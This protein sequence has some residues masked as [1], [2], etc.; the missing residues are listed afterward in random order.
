MPHR[1]S[2]AA[3]SC[4]PGN[5][6]R[7]PRAGSLA[8]AARSRSS[9]AWRAPTRCPAAYARRS[10]RQ[11]TTTT[12]V[13][14]ASSRAEITGS[15]DMS[16]VY[17][18]FAVRE[19]VIGCRHP[20]C[21]EESGMRYDLHTHYYPPSYFELIRRAPGE[22]SFGTDPTGRTIIRHRGARFFGVTAPMTDPALRLADMDRVGIDV[23]VL[24]LSTPN[25]FF[26]EPA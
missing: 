25:V 2:V 13:N 24:S 14:P 5:G 16:G 23:E 18:S 6:W 12:S 8:G 26:A 4:A 1:P 20:S 15:G 17:A 10:C 3:S 11:S 9:C 22:F 7:P 19:A 21:E